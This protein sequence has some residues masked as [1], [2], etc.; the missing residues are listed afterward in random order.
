LPSKLDH[1]EVTALASRCVAAFVE[2]FVDIDSETGGWSKYYARDPEEVGVWGTASAIIGIC[3][4]RE[5]GVDLGR[6][7]G[8]VADMVRRACRFLTSHQVAEGRNRGAW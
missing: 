2:S 5:L 3:L 1:T 4:G 6:P 7:D 8:V